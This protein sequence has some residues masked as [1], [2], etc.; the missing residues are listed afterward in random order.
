MNLYRC[1]AAPLQPFFVD[2]FC[3]RKIRYMPDFIRHSIYPLFVRI[4]Y[5]INHARQ[6]IS[7][8]ARHISGSLEHIENPAGDLYRC[9]AAPLQPFFVDIFCLRK[10]RYM[11]DFIRHSIYPLFVRIRYDINHARQGISSVARHISG[12]LEHIENPA[13]DLY[14]CKA[15]PLQPF[16][17]DIF[18]LRKIRYMPDFIRHSIY[19]LFVRIRYDINHARQGISSVARHISGSLEHIENPAG[20]L[21]RCKAA[22]CKPL[23]KQCK[24][25]R[26]C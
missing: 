10:I 15:A 25:K 18:C 16:F 5:D 17:V 14:R 20:D 19:P 9:K 12:S 2:I 21:Y 4:R 7:S 8:V 11:P 3:L 6:G 26:N 1:K 23:H 24:S 22:P 13:G